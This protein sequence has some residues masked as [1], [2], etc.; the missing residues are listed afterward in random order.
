MANTLYPMRGTGDQE[1]TMEV[2]VTSVLNW[3]ALPIAESR[4]N[5]KESLLN[6]YSDIMKQQ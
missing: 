3:G 5:Q 2:S 6:L 1:I 4:N